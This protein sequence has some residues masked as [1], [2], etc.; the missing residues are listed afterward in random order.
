M[1]VT[2]VQQK[3]ERERKKIHDKDACDSSRHMASRNENA[4]AD[5]VL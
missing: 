4:I 5:V 1:I 2:T 3:R